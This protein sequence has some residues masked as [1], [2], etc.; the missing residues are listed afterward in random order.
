M[1]EKIIVFPKGSSSMEISSQKISTSALYAANNS[2]WFTSTLASIGGSNLRYRV[3]RNMSAQFH[4]HENTPEG[5][6]VLSGQVS[7]DTEF[8]SVS[9]DPGDFFEIK[10]GINHRAR[11]VGEATL[12]VFDAIDS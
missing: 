1:G 11:V 7:I 2:A 12:L 9:L 6:F 8:G 10:P 5:F 4:T 3:M